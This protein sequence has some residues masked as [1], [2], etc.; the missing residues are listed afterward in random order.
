M[1][2]RLWKSKREKVKVYFSFEI[3]IGNIGQ[4]NWWILIYSQ[5]ARLN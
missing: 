1:G 5:T 3:K 2:Y 4:I